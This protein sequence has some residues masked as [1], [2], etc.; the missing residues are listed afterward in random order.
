LEYLE[1]ALESDGSPGVYGHADSAGGVGG[2]ATVELLCMGHAVCDTVREIILMF[3]RCILV[4]KEC[5]L[6]GSHAERLLH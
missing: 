3:V 2:L 5:Y 1:G 4:V 6:V